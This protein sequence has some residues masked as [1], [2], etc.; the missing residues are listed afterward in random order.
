MQVTTI[1]HSPQ[2]SPQ[3]HNRPL[4]TPS[5][6]TRSPSARTV[7]NSSPVL[8][9]HLYLTEADDDESLDLTVPGEDTGINVTS[10][11]ENQVK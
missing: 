8:F 7:G 2:L 6:F 10:L 1:A 3:I 9:R 4:R 5:R 11:A